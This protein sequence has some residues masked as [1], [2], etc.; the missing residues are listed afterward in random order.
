MTENEAWYVMDWDRLAG[1]KG[2]LCN[3][4]AT[5]QKTSLVQVRFVDGFTAVINRRAL[6]RAKPS[7]IKSLD[8]TPDSD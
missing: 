3:M 2:Q 1:R 8:K 6:R 5:P 4:L 7:E